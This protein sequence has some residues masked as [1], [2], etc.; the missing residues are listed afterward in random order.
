M[1]TR[2]RGSATALRLLG[3][4]ALILGIVLAFPAEAKAQTHGVSIFKTCVSP[5]TSCNSDTDCADPNSCTGFGICTSTGAGHMN[6]CSITLTNSDPSLD[7]IRV[8]AAQDTVFAAAGNQ[9]FTLLPISGTTGTT[10]G[11]CTGSID[12]AVGCIL[13][14]GAS[15]TFLSNQYVIQATDP[16][17]LVDQGSIQV[18][19]L[20]NVNPV[21]CSTVPNTVQFTA[22]TDLVSGCTPGAPCT[23]TATPTNTPTNTPTATETPG[24]GPP[25]PSVPTLS[26]PMLALLGLILAGAGLFLARRQ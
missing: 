20:C 22:S 4:G 5:K 23:P 24:E 15:V 6:E 26:F 2:F 9:T 18:Q 1:R 19:D 3:S 14:P 13:D 25:P 8:N 10:S 7:D 21:G 17:P 16:N 12:P 11:D